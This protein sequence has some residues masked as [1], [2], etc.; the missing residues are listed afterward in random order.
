MENRSKYV[1]AVLERSQVFEKVTDIM[2]E[3]N[4]CFPFGK[5]DV[6]TI[7]EDTS[8]NDIGFDSLDEADMIMRMEIAFNVSIPYEFEMFTVKDA[9]DEIIKL[10][11]SE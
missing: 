2:S 6:S 1:E 8:F 7:T 10:K 3:I 4:G 5:I 11:K 9:V